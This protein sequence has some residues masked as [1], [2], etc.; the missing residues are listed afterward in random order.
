MFRLNLS[1]QLHYPANGHKKKETT[2]NLTKRK[3]LKRIRSFPC[4]P[5]PLEK[6]PFL[7][8]SSTYSFF[9][10]HFSFSNK[11]KCLELPAFNQYTAAF[12]TTKPPPTT[13]CIERYGLNLYI[14]LLFTSHENWLE[15]QRLNWKKATRRNYGV[16]AF[17]SQ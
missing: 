17:V 3:P 16:F 11:L 15:W 6:L 10:S 7:E 9:S 8:S 4:F 13:S 12:T 1:S 5:L 2:L 14:V